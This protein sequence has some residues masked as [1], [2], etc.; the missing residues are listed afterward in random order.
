MMNYKF[1]KTVIPFVVMLAT[2]SIFAQKYDRK[3]T[4]KFSVD[5]DVEIAINASNTEISVSNWDKNEVEITA[6]IEIEGISKEAAEKYF[7]NWNFEA[8]GN[9]SKVKITTQ[10]NNRFPFNND[11]V[12]LD[13][14]NF[15]F[16]NVFELDSTFMDK[17]IMPKV[18]FDFNL[19]NDFMFWDAPSFE[20]L[21]GKNGKYTFH[22]KDD[23]NDIKIESKED[24]EKFKKSKDYKK[25]KEKMEKDREKMR[26]E[27][28]ASREKMKREMEKN[29]I[30]IQKID[31]E[32][33]QQQLEKARQELA[34]VKMHFSTES[35]NVMIDGKKVKITKKI[36]I[37]APKGATFDLNTRHCKVKLPST[38]AVGNVKYGSFDA[39]NLNNSKLTINYSPVNINDISTSNLFLNNVTD[40]KIASVTNTKINTNY[41]NVT[42]QNI[43]KNVEL[44]TKFGDVH[45]QKIHSDYAKFLL[46]L[47]YTNAIV[48][49]QNL[50][51]NL[52][53][54]IKSMTNSTTNPSMKLN[55]LRDK[56]K[57]IN[58]NFT[59]KTKDSTFFINGKYS[60]VT[61]NQ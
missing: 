58:G 11:V 38:V 48:N 39:N 17:M 12:F 35:D 52:L 4:E 10:T 43:Y 40:A 28:E 45:I 1:Y 49:L 20:N 61:V 7:K 30:Y 5:K 34:K 3:Y 56:S 32:K 60:Q 47:N 6:Y 9:K 16:P 22:F 19:N 37:K 44:S 42:I 51:K 41:S 59:I 27:F 53:F 8:L 54:E 46:Y 57:N 21:I 14:S 31:K 15:N 24:W 2:T 50:D 18:D 26:N 23:E 55:V 13:N 36:E 25:W 33:L 29:K